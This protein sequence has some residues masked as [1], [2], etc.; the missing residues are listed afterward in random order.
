MTVTT[1]RRRRFIS[2]LAAV[3]GMALLPHAAGRALGAAAG[4]PAEHLHVWE[5]SVLGGDAMMQLH[6]PDAAEARRL[7]EEVLAEVKRLERVFSLYDPQ[8]AISRLNRAG[9]IEE[10]PIE[11]VELLGQ[12]E[13]FSQLTSGAFDATVQPLWDLYA[14]HFTCADADPAGPSHQAIAA[15]LR[16]VGHSAIELDGSRVGFAKPGM[17]I[18]LNGIA[19]GYITDR[20]VDLL[21]RRGINR[22]L[23][24]M[25]EIRAIGGRPLGGPWLVGLQDP[26]NPAR[27]DERVPIENRAVA[28]SG[29]YGTLFDPA[30][31]FNHLFDP[32]SGQ[33]SCR[34]LAVSVIA[35]DTTTA[36]AL[37]TAFS[38][39]PLD[40]TQQ[41][42]RRLRLVAR[43]VLPDGHHIWQVG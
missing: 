6:H 25:G 23:V 39:M 13:Q 20:V 33:T 14:T 27:I 7:I 32:A 40:R 12:S 8:S 24:D 38:L 26:R 36:D 10:P 19:E 28:T 30:G 35:P 37:S 11:L 29:G 43:F 2:I 1:M 41:V 18:T 3:P 31:R 4:D 15:A 16:R 5:G 17:A 21:R 34:Y 42:V 9:M 22:S